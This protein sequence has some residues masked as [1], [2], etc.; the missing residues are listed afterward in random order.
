MMTGLKAAL[1]GVY[2]Y[3]W[4]PL[5][6]HVLHVLLPPPGARRLPSLPLVLARADTVCLTSCLSIGP[7]AAVTGSL[8][9]RPTVVAGHVKPDIIS[10]TG[11]GFDSIEF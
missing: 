2:G 8:N 3:G 4:A 5:A 1:L 11:Y 6:P 10:D 7:V 9:G